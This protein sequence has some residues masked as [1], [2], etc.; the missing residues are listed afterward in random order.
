MRCRRRVGVVVLAAFGVASRSRVGL[1]SWRAGDASAQGGQASGVSP[2][3]T[4]RRS[5][6]PLPR[7][8]GGCRSS[9]S[10]SRCS[11]TARR[12]S[13]LTVRSAA[14]ASSA[15]RAAWSGSTAP[16]TIT[17]TGSLFIT[18]VYKMSADGAGVTYA[19]CV[20]VRT[21]PTVI[22][23]CTDCGDSFALSA[24]RDREFGR[25]GRLRRCRDCR[26][27]AGRPTPAAIEQAK[28]WWL[29]RY[30]LEELRAW[31]PW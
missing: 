16:E 20:A 24:R 11:R 7:S 28:R 3:G 23:V 25:L 2:T 10:R 13:A 4:A 1:W 19:L 9:C 31:P 15:S 18:R 8:D 14:R 5:P 29:A 17:L 30:P 12:S 27:V 22:V 21:S 6:S 26:G